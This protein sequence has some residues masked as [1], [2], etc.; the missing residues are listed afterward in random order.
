M[1]CWEQNIV[2]LS[3]TYCFK[4]EPV[5]L[6]DSKQ[7]ARLT[8]KS[9][10]GRSPSRSGLGKKCS[11]IAEVFHRLPDSKS[12]KLP[13][14]SLISLAVT[15]NYNHPIA[16]KRTALIKMQLNYMLR[17]TIKR[18]SFAGGPIKRRSCA[19]D[20]N[21]FGKCD[22]E[23]KLQLAFKPVKLFNSLR[24]L[25][26]VRSITLSVLP[27]WCRSVTKFDVKYSDILAGNVT[28][29]VVYWALPTM[30]IIY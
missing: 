20:S 14:S 7:T 29:F 22:P 26:V 21:C 11:R 27:N 6:E 30:L 23:E 10:T 5:H 2:S 12:N 8:S 9:S 13:R 1:K 19:Q 17:L 3:Q 15:L 4:L 16:I 24:R 18:C 28:H 25:E